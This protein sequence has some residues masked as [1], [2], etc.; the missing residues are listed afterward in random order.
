MMDVRKQLCLEA[1][2][3]KEIADNV[4]LLSTVQA[5][6][7]ENEKSEG[8][9]ALTVD[10]DLPGENEKNKNKSRNISSADVY[11]FESRLINKDDALNEL[12]EKIKGHGLIYDIC[13]KNSEKLKSTEEKTSTPSESCDVTV[14]MTVDKVNDVTVVDKE[15]DVTVEMTV[16]KVDG[17]TVVDKVDDVTVEMTVDKVNDVIVAS[18]EINQN[19][20]AGQVHDLVKITIPGQVHQ[21]ALVESQGMGTQKDEINT[22]IKE[23]NKE[24]YTTAK[25]NLKK[26]DNSLNKLLSYHPY[27]VKYISKR[28][29]LSALQILCQTLPN[30]ATLLLLRENEQTS[31]E[32]SPRFNIPQV[33]YI[34]ISLV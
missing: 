15:D 10:C 27:D 31:S 4:H 5:E 24:N 34:P 30:A 33:V 26:E 16:D 1:Y 14:E 21:S 20:I 7:K 6:S 29:D 3:K 17:V 8:R 32:T 25:E 28:K 19:V 23:E 2:H 12:N 13:L 18:Q 9:E 22:N 11:A